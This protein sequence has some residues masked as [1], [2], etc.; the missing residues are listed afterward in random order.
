MLIPGFEAY[1][2]QKKVSKSSLVQQS[3]GDVHRKNDAISS[4]LLLQKTGDYLV[5]IS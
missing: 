2:A 1:W 4:E 3:I 5:I